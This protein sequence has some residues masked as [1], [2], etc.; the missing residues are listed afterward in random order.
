MKKGLPRGT[1]S[2]THLGESIKTAPSCAHYGLRAWPLRGDPH[3][4]PSRVSQ[5]CWF[6][7]LDLGD[8]PLG[9]LQQDRWHNQGGGRAVLQVWLHISVL[10]R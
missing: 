6:S 1:C 5:G 10:S 7:L 3:P 4:G 9:R 8:H 2:C